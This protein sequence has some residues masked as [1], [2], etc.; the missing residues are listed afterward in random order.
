MLITPTH[1]AVRE[2]PVNKSA[3]ILGVSCIQ[4]GDRRLIYEY[5]SNVIAPVQTCSYRVVGLNLWQKIRKI[6]RADYIPVGMKYALGC[7]TARVRY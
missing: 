2:K 3:G 6:N 7:F 5:A 4:M 1:N